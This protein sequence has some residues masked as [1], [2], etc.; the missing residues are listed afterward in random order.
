VRHQLLIVELVTTVEN[1]FDLL[2]LSFFLPSIRGA[3]ENEESINATAIYYWET[4]GN[5]ER[6]VA[7]AVSEYFPAQI[8]VAGTGFTGFY[9]HQPTEVR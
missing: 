4:V 3:V 1:L 5:Q 9:C 7:T 8:A 6:F 2:L